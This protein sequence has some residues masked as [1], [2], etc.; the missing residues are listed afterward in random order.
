MSPARASYRERQRAEL[1]AAIARTALRLFAEHG[2]DNVTTEAIAAEVGISLSTLFRNVESKEDLLVRPLLQGRAQIVDNFAARPADEPV[3][4]S[5]AKAILLRTEQFAAET[6][7]VRQWRTAMHSA[8]ASIQ[9]ASIISAD[10]R[11]R[12]VAL[13]AARMGVDPAQDLRPGVLVR[14]MFAAADH[15]FELWLDGGTHTPLHE[16]TTQALA[17]AGAVL[18]ERGAAR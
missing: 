9:R 16:L 10:E 15:A 3:T 7:T 11:V 1:R 6:E 2:F 4:T 18:P 14:M 5:L 8:P 12:L 17:C 13:A